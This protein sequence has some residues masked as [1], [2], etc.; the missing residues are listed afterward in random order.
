VNPDLASQNRRVALVAATAM[1]LGGLG[2]ILGGPFAAEPAAAAS[3]GPA[4][5]GKVAVMVVIDPGSGPVQQ[6]CVTVDAGR[7]GMDALYAA[8]QVRPHPSNGGFVCGI[9][10]VPPAPE[11]AWGDPAADSWSYW[12]AS[13]GGSWQFSTVGAAGRRLPDRCA[14]EGWSFRP[15]RAKSPPRV[16]P[17]SVACEAAAAPPAAAPKPAPAPPRPAT[18]PRD[19]GGP[20][21]PS[22]SVAPA[23]PAGRGGGTATTAPGPSSGDADAGGAPSSTGRDAPDGPDE[24]AAAAEEPDA[25]ADD[26]ERG[27][28]DPGAEELADPDEATSV[29]LGEEVAAGARDGDAGGPPWVGTLVVL[30]AIAALGGG[31]LL[32]S[33]RTRGADDA[34][35]A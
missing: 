35:G 1:L 14:V 19:G 32:R 24:P 29:D 22:G 20:A 25:P 18:R 26:E 17:P 30:L 34:G 10:G 5:A 2:A 3:C 6:R 13:P 23:N 21:G 11:C 4:P 8:A 16:A 7:T 9:G 15:Q 28:H 33:R 27:E 31:A 12:Y